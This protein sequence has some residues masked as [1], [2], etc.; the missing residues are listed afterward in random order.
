MREFADFLAR[1][2]RRKCW[3]LILMFIYTFVVWNLGK[4][5]KYTFN[6]VQQ[7]I[8]EVDDPPAPDRKFLIDLR[9]FDYTINQKSCRQLKIK[10]R[11]IVLVHSSPTKRENRDNIRQ[12]W[13]GWKVD[14]RVIFLFGAVASENLQ[15]E[16]QAESDFFGDIVQGN[17]VDSYR[18]LSY[19]HVMAMKWTSEFC[20]EAKF[21][22]KSDDD[23]FVNTPLLSQF[24]QTLG[25]IPNFILCAMSWKPPVVRDATSKWYVSPEE[26]PNATY[27]VY[28]PG[29]GVLMSTDVAKKLHKAAETTPFF[30]VDDV[31]VLGILREKIR[32]KITPVASLLLKSKISDE[33]FYENKRNITEVLR[34]LYS[35]ELTNEQIKDIWGVVKNASDSGFYSVKKL[36]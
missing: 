27:P 12:S 8:I 30:W 19:K 1:N 22:F 15:R 32:V 36:H 6:V 26:Y 34:Y 3:I 11:F 29:C 28:C 18:N 7:K 14:H 17:F 25:G 21:I 10:P 5:H 9:N 2:A 16:I 33:I 35:F 20:P 23:I 4:S 13:G 24:V 31:F